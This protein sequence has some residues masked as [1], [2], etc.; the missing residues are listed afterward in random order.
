M[1]LR[2]NRAV[3]LAAAAAVLLV[4]GLALALFWAPEDADQGFSY[5]KN[6]WVQLRKDGRTCYGQIQD[7]GPAQYDDAEYVF[8]RG[9]ARPANERY[10]GAGMDVSP[11][12]T[13]VAAAAGGGATGAW[14]CA[15]TGGASVERPRTSSCS[16]SDSS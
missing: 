6:R 14:P 10:N 7:A 8:G 2:N 9:D 1:S 4:A 16:T 15:G 3:L 12:G 5:L 13:G 11:D